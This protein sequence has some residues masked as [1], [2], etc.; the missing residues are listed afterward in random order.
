MMMNTGQRFLVHRDDLSQTRVQPFDAGSPL[1]PGRIRCR[2]AHFALTANNI[3]YAVFGESMRYW[4]FFPADDRWGCIPVWGFA[5]VEASACDGVTCGERLYGYWPMATHAQLEPVGVRDDGF[6]DGSAHRADLPP[7]YNRY[8]RVPRD[9]GLQAEGQTA[10]LRPLFTTAWLLADFLQQ[11]SDFAA[12]TL[13]LSSASS[14]TALATAYC[15]REREG[16][17]PAVVGATSAPRHAFVAGLGLFDD[18]ITYDAVTTLDAATHTLY[19]D[20]AGDTGFRR[21][22]HTHWHERLVYSCAVGVTHHDAFDPTRSGAALP[23]PKP[24]FFFAPTRMQQ[25]AA[26][27]PQGLGRAA[28]LQCI[29]S[30]WAAFAEHACGGATPWLTVGPRAGTDALR[31]AY[32]DT[33]HG[34]ADAQRGLLLSL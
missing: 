28:L 19:I 2:I 5:E 10:L 7:V 16:P 17:R 23:G 6:A 27:P 12:R 30:A 14:K 21:A 34:R 1:A 26:P 3:T 20:F 9:A 29:D 25:R 15:L 22:V 33:L 31:A 4:Q 24:Q 18:V 11:E 32:L 8:Q 13:L